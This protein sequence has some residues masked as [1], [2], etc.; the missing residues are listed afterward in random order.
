MRLG[1]DHGYAWPPHAIFSV[2]EELWARFVEEMRELDRNLRREMREDAPS[3]ERIRFFATS[4]NFDGDPWLTLPRTFFLEDENEYFQSDV[5][6]RHNRMLSRA[7]WQTALRRTPLTGL[8]GG[9][10]GADEIPDPTGGSEA[11]QS[12][13]DPRV[14]KGTGKDGPKLLGPALTGKEGARALDHRPKDRKSGKFLCWDNITHRGCKAASCVHH[15]GPAPKWSSMDWSVQ[16]QLLRRGGLKGKPALSNDQV[17]QQMEQIRKANRDKAAE[18]VEEGK[19]MKSSGKGKDKE[20]TTGGDVEESPAKVGHEPP[21]ELMDFMPTTAEGTLAAWV[22]NAGSDFLGKVEDE[23]QGRTVSATVVPDGDGKKRLQL[24]EA[25]DNSEVTKMLDGHLATYVNNQLLLQ[26]EEDPNVQLDSQAVA[27][28]LEK[29][30]DLGPPIL[31]AA[32][33]QVLTEGTAGKVGYAQELATLTPMTW[34]QG[35]G[36]GEFR[37]LGTR[38]SVYD[39]GDELPISDGL[40][41]LL[42]LED[43]QC[44][45]E[46]I[47]QCL[48]LHCTASYLL[49]K[50]GRIPTKEKVQEAT[51][52]VRMEAV[53]QAREAAYHLGACPMEVGKAE[54]DVRV[55]A[56]DILHLDHDK[57]YRCLAAF[58]PSLF[59]GC[60]LH[61]VRMDPHGAVTTEIIRNPSGSGKP[62]LELW[63]LVSKCHMRVLNKPPGATPPKAV[64]E[65]EA[66]GWEVH[67]EAVAG[68]EACVRA[69]D[70]ARCPR[71]DEAAGDPLRIGD[72]SRGPSVLGLYPPTRR[73]EVG[74]RG[75]WKCEICPMTIALRM[76]TLRHG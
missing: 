52:E 27:R 53:W 63:L 1:E 32:A 72:G 10:A 74:S 54:A 36:R 45:K 28:A 75:T 61:M 57:D 5:V 46:E 65:V 43:I 67:L 29:A 68:P 7:C 69:R 33:D 9:K 16:L 71:C 12:R 14:G 44:Q 47:R 3:F 40:V 34:N 49:A 6:P 55:F 70:L 22:E 21:E 35:V 18:N 50:Q 26:L 48:Y 11:L 41:D 30:R 51:K 19:R 13:P 39:Y 42:D 64:R 60:T 56:H 15:H 25:I 31:S 20:R 76:R 23:G 66:A 17:T 24:M 37:Y 38:W 59:E 58:P 73:S 4:P 62:Q 2:W 8:T